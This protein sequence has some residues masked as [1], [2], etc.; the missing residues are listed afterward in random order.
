M[1]LK[2]RGSPCRKGSASQDLMSSEDLTNLRREYRSSTLDELDVDLNPFV[3]FDKWFQQTLN[4]RVP[5][6]NA[7]VLDRDA[8]GAALCSHGAVE[9]L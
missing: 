1:Y 6:P 4:A 8:G 5:E 9:E 2:R 3:Q 7:M